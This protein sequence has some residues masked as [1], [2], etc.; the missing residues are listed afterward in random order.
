M[1][2]A[3]RRDRVEV[4]GRAQGRDADLLLTRALEEAQHQVAGAVAAAVVEHRVERREPLLR[5]VRVDVGQLGGKTLVDHLRDG[6][7]LA[8]LLVGLLGVT[9]A[10]IVSRPSAPRN[11]PVGSPTGRTS[12]RRARAAR[13]AREDGAWTG[14]A[15]PAVFL[16]TVRIHA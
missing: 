5:L 3:L 13:V 4:V 7:V 8:G 15:A 11:L 12:H 1:T 9:H 10:L 6:R 2:A 16:W 14:V